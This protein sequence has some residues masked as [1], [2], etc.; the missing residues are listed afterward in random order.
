MSKIWATAKLVLN[1]HKL[2]QATPAMEKLANKINKIG[3]EGVIDGDT[4]SED[5]FYSM[6]THSRSGE[7]SEMVE[8]GLPD[9][10]KAAAGKK[11]WWFND[12]DGEWMDVCFMFGTEKQIIAKLTQVA[13]D[14]KAEH[15]KII[16]ETTYTDPL[17]VK[18]A[19]EI[20][21]KFGGT[22]SSPD[23]SIDYRNWDRTDGLRLS[24]GGT[25]FGQTLKLNQVTVSKKNGPTTYFTNRKDLD[26]YLDSLPVDNIPT[27]LL[28]H[29]HLTK[30]YFI[31]RDQI[32]PQLERLINKLRDI[33]C[34]EVHGLITLR[35][36]KITV[37]PEW[38]ARATEV[39]NLNLLS[40]LET[41]AIE[42]CKITWGFGINNDRDISISFDLDKAIA[43]AKGELQLIATTAHVSCKP[44]D[45]DAFPRWSDTEMKAL[46][47][48]FLES[49]DAI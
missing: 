22:C 28:I 10:K 6:D 40:I 39:G 31:R 25:G 49:V 44:C 37:K 29:G 2:H 47:Q 24:F 48:A 3:G 8:A 33:P 45:P 4:L 1:S 13:A 41:H 9:L 12:P 19:E 34:Y 16:K 42:M 17:T 27:G 26:N 7:F 32:T 30:E 36:P 23:L 14:A 5:L 46:A 15:D 21:Q 20:A 43:I 35:L 11:A 18:I 38:S